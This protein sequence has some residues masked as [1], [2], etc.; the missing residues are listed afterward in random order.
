MPNDSLLLLIC[1]VTAGIL[2]VG[3]AVY[4]LRWH[5]GYAERYAA[6]SITVPWW[7]FL[8]SAVFFLSMAAWSYTRGR[9]SFALAFMAFVALELV[10]MTSAAW[11][12][13]TRKASKREVPPTS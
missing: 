11:R 13:T 3:L 1:L 9:R 6:W 4:T 2:G 10:A 12:H 8:A 7:F 5:R